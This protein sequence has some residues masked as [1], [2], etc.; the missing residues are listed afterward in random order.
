MNKISDR[1][2]SSGPSLSGGGEHN[3]GGG[4]EDSICQLEI[5]NQVVPDI[6]SVGGSQ[7]VKTNKTERK[8]GRARHDEQKRMKED[9]TQKRQSKKRIAHNEK[10]R[11]WTKR[12][13]D[14]SSGW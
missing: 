3:E 10:R 9:K 11:R 5:V 6:T 13:T 2:S 1:K 8:T 7:K 14:L 12:K 4:R